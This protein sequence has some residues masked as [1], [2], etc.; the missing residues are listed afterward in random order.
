MQE[1]EHW[2]QI[3]ATFSVKDHVREGAFIAEILLYDYLYIPTLATVADGLTKEE[4][5]KERKR[6]VEKGWDPAKQTQLVA[7]LLNGRIKERI[8][9]IP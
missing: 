7:R 6:W 4:A 9:P 1:R 2:H 3:C 8:R 5:N